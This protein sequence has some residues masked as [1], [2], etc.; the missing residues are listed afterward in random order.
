MLSSAVHA[1]DRTCTGMSE[2]L[3]KVSSGAR[4]YWKIEPL[5][6][7]D[8]EDFQFIDYDMI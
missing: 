4:A 8:H 7:E 1:T 6:K 3:W 2:N 5:N